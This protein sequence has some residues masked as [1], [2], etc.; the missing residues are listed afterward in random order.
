[1]HALA[2]APK[3]QWARSAAETK[4]FGIAEGSTQGATAL[5]RSFRKRHSDFAM[6]CAAQPHEVTAFQV[7]NYKNFVEWITGSGWRA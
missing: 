5:R 7:V 4:Q 3:R 2:H 6:L 1:L